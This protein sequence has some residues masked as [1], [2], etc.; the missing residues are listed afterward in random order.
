MGP[1]AVAPQSHRG[2]DRLSASYLIALAARVIQEVRSLL[3]RSKELD[4]RLPTWSLDTEL[5][6]R[7]A[8]DGAA[9]SEE[10]TKARTTLAAR[11]HD[12][13]TPGGPAHRIVVV[14]HPLLHEP[15]A[16]KP[17]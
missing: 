2:A 10:L 4:Q 7:S 3:R 13:S 12:A 9:F 16:R 15:R 17:S 1:A 6:F 8:A 14:A 5:R 11:Y